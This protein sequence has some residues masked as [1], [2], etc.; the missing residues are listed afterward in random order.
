MG[1]AQIAW[2]ILGGGIWL[3]DG[4]ELLLV[5]AVTRCAQRWG[6]WGFDPSAIMGQHEKRTPVDTL[7]VLQWVV[8]ISV[9]GPFLGFRDNYIFGRQTQIEPMKLKVAITANL[10]ISLDDNFPLG[11]C[12]TNQ[13]PEAFVKNQGPGIIALDAHS[14]NECS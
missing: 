13:L 8:I 3:A 10:N 12:E 9:H 6:L 14:G 4:A 2:G 1:P 7:H 11:Y 5:S